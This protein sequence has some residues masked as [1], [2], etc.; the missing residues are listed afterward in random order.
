MVGVDAGAHPTLL[1]KVSPMDR[2]CP[3]KCPVYPGIARA[4]GC[5]GLFD[6]K[7]IES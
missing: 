7:R 1:P 6:E 5:W 3:S 4:T 2:V